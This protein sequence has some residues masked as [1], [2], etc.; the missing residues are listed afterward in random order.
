MKNKTFIALALALIFLI[1]VAVGSSVMGSYAQKEIASEIEQ[2]NTIKN[3]LKENN[4]L[5]SSTTQKLMEAQNKLKTE[6]IKTTKL[7][8]DLR[9]A[10]ESLDA[11]KKEL[12]AANIIIADL[13]SNEYELV[14]IGEFKITHYCNEP[15]EHICG[16]GDGLTA[17]G[18]KVTPGR[19][20]AVDPKV[21]P[22]GTEV[23][24]E[25]YG[26]RVAED[27]GGAIKGNDIDMAVDTHSEAMAMGV[28]H[29]GVW[30]LVKKT[31]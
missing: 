4:K 10:I 13:K 9:H 19:T 3:E 24:I 11:L 1:G 7:D 25:G 31:S 21:I 26:W 22:Y 8:S 30:I 16:Y 2:T 12:E 5:L 27:C 6:T 15:Y 20:I 28:K 29:G 23:Y 18:T 17:T 14:Y